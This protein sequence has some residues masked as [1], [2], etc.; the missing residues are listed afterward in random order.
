[1]RRVSV[2]DFKH[3]AEIQENTTAATADGTR[4]AAVW[5]TIAEARVKLEPISGFRAVV[6]GQ[7]QSVVNFRIVLRWFD[8]MTVG[9]RL[10]IGTREFYCDSLINIDERNQFWEALCV[11][12]QPRVSV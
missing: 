6:N 8:G 12:G 11:E 3:L 10:V 1:M 7:M 2:G 9:C 4:P 5:R